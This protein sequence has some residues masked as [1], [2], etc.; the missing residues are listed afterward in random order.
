MLNLLFSTL[1]F[2][3]SAWYLN[4]YLDRQD[5]GQG[6]TRGVLVFLLASLL[7][8]AVAAAVDWVQ[9][10]IDNPQATLQTGLPQLLKAAGNSRP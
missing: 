4:R 8:W 9:V 3:I 7:S 1:V 5:I 6:M 10:K 2:F